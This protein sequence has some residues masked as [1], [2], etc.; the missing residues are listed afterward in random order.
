M[1]DG[2]DWLTG[3]KRRRSLLLEDCAQK[4]KR[5]KEEGIFLAETERYWQA[6]RKFDEALQLTPG[7]AGLHDMK[8]QVLMLLR[9]D[10]A[11]VQAAHEA[12]Q[13]QPMCWTAHQTL[14]RARLALGEIRMALRSFSTAV[15]LNPSDEELRRDDLLYTLYL[16]RSK[17]TAATTVQEQDSAPL[18]FDEDGNLVELPEDGTLAANLVQCREVH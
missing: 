3:F 12:V 14:G 17:E 5:L 15:H 18:L 1:L 7:D 16:C 6:I 2:V 9:E 8:A 13:L 4:S 10:F 11:A